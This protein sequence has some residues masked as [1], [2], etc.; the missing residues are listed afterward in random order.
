MPAF[1]EIKS[2]LSPGLMWLKGIGALVLLL[3][4][5]TYSYLDHP[6]GRYD[7]GQ[8][9]LSL[10][11][12]ATRQGRNGSGPKFLNWQDAQ[13]AS[14]NGNGAEASA[15][16]HKGPIVQIRRGAASGVLPEKLRSVP[17]GV[18]SN[19]TSAGGFVRPGR[20]RDSASR[21]RNALA[22]SDALQSL[23][24]A[25]SQTVGRMV[26]GADRARVL[27]NPFL[28]ALQERGSD[29]ADTELPNDPLASQSD[30]GGRPQHPARDNGEAD[31]SGA[32]E[33]A[34]VE[35]QRERRE[36]PP[37]DDGNPSGPGE[38][39]DSGQDTGNDEGSADEPSAD[40]GNQDSQQ[41]PDSDPATPPSSPY[42][43]LI[44]PPPDP[45]D[46]GRRVFL[47]RRDENDEEIFLLEDGSSFFF[48]QS[49]LPTVV[50]LEANHL[51]ATSDFNFDGLLDLVRVR[52]GLDSCVLEVFLRDQL[53]PNGYDAMSV[54]LPDLSV[55]SFAFLD[56]D[57]DNLLD[58]AVL[59]EGASS[60]FI[61][62]LDMQERALRLLEERQLPFEPALLIDWQVIHT[63]GWPER[64]LF[65]LDES[66]RQA[67]ATGSFDP[68][69]IVQ[70]SR[71][72][73]FRSLRVVWPSPV[74]PS[75]T[76]VLVFESDDRIAMVESGRSGYRLSALFDTSFFSPMAV[77]GDFQGSGTRQLLVL[78]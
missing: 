68:D 22:E 7:I 52:N 39:P 8:A 34:P 61:F 36:D 16:L 38:S 72:P 40:E 27:E 12:R 42:N 49:L 25:E 56:F 15:S 60:L 66:F 20:F 10:Q 14:S 74:G 35:D 51:F 21:I 5:P 77:M 30:D 29:D 65:I 17:V 4:L 45:Q 24:V 13:Q 28:A 73:P 1:R 41:D 71:I 53:Q 44:V 78:P 26:A 48:P 6:S 3:A 32:D 69:S 58:M 55:S 18:P 50:G 63:G 54:Q 70:V 23:E 43:F 67:A 33:T 47:A 59:F 64:I 37:A 75:E 57:L 9:E 76:E 11:Q 2:R 31:G 62:R 46:E 19:V